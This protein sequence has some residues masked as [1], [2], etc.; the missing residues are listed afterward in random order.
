MVTT[1]REKEP[2]RWPIICYGPRYRLI[3]GNDRDDRHCRRHIASAPSGRYR[4]LYLG[5]QWRHSLQTLSHRL[6]SRRNLPCESWSAAAGYQ[7]R[8]SRVATHRLD[9]STDTTR[10]CKETILS[11]RLLVL[12]SS[13]AIC[14][15]QQKAEFINWECFPLCFITVCWWC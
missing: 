2:Y 4:W 8:D 1:K 12:Q 13:L 3:T 10:H 14:C 11:V 6:N 7:C 9:G 15:L 5:L